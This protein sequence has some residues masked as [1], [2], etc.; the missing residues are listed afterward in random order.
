M[1]HVHW[2]ASLRSFVLVAVATVMVGSV[3]T[4]ANA[5]RTV[6]DG[7]VQ[8]SGEALPASDAGVDTTAAGTVT[9]ELRVHD[10]RDGQRSVVREGQGHALLFVSGRGA[11]S[12][13]QVAALRDW[14]ARGFTLPRGVEYSTIWVP[15][16][17]E[18]SERALKSLRSWPVPVFRDSR[19]RAAATAYGAGRPP[20]WVL[21][22]PG[23]VL[24]ARYSGFLGIE[25]LAELLYRFGLVPRPGSVS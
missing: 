10:R 25:N 15:D 14:F 16:R 21:V 4:E 22:A 6:G 5:F 9:P 3:A 24:V 20:V 18:R 7:R 13:R 11:A 23:G 2:T 12:R 1:T 8:V 19:R 17:S